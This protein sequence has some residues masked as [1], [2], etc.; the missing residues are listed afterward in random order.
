MTLNTEQAHPSNKSEEQGIQREK[1]EAIEKARINRAADVRGNTVHGRPCLQSILFHK[2][3][4]CSTK[5]IVHPETSPLNLFRNTDT[6][7]YS[8]IPQPLEFRMPL[9]QRPKI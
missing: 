7:R 4:L 8:V 9:A 2:K 1:W 6:R 5:V 3:R